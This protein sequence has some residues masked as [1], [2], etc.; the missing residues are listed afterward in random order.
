MDECRWPGCA[1]RGTEARDISCASDPEPPYGEPEFVRAFALLPRD[2]LD[3]LI[4]SDEGQVHLP[5]LALLIQLIRQI[6]L[7]AIYPYTAFV[8]G[9]GLMSYGS[10]VNS[11]F[12]RQAAQVAE[13]FRGANPGD[14]PY[15]QA[16]RF[17]FVVN[18]KTAKELGIEMP[19]S[20][21]AGATA[22]IE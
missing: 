1:R 13:I 22:L 19:A 8:E 18:L 14:I 15:S 20:L 6:R 9:G 2:Q 16:V 10:D 21:V 7:P 11:S 5:R 4:L 17:D 12:R 3:G